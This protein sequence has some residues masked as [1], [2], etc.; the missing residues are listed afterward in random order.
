MKQQNAFWAFILA[1]GMLGAV[2]GG[3]VAQENGADQESTV[4]HLAG[5]GFF[6]G[7]LTAV[8]SVMP[9]DREAVQVLQQTGMTV[10]EP[11][12]NQGRPAADPV[13]AGLRPWDSTAA[14][15]ES[16]VAER[17][18][19]P[20]APSVRLQLGKYYAQTG[21]FDQALDQWRE[22][23]LLTRDRA[24]GQSVH[25]QALGRHALLLAELGQADEL[26]SLVAEHTDRRPEAGGAGY[27]WDRAQNILQ[28]SRG[29][30]ESRRRGLAILL[31]PFTPEDSPVTPQ[32]FDDTLI[33]E[34]D[35]GVSP[36][37]LIALADS[38][39]LDVRIAAP[40]GNWEP[41]VPSIV[42]LTVGTYVSVIRA[43]AGG[44]QIL[45]PAAG[46][47]QWVTPQELRE[48]ASGVV[49]VAAAVSE[50]DWPGLQA[51][52]SL[53]NVGGLPSDCPPFDDEDGPLCDEPC[54]PCPPGR[55]GNDA[56]LMP[57]A[58]PDCDSCGTAADSPGMVVWRVSEPF[59]NV[60]LEDVP[61][62]YEP[63]IGPS[64][65]LELGHRQRLGD[66]FG[67]YDGST[68]G[69]GFHASWR[70]SAGPFGGD[71]HYVYHPGGRIGHYHFPSSSSLMSERNYWDNS[72][73]EKL[74]DGAS[75][76]SRGY[77]LHRP[78]GSMLRYEHNFL[79][80]GDFYLT[81]QVDPQGNQLAFNYDAAGRLTTVVDADGRSTRLVYQGTS[82]LIREVV[83]PD[84]RRV[85]F[86]Y[87]WRY[88]SD[89]YLVSITDPVGI[90]SSFQYN[91]EWIRS[92]S[93]P[94]GTTSFTT[95]A[96]SGSLSRW[97]RVDKPEGRTHGYALVDTSAVGMPA[98]IPAAQRPN[99]SFPN[100]L[101]LN[102][103]HHRNTFYWNPQQWAA[104]GQT[105]I[106]GFGWTQYRRARIR[107]WLWE[108]QRHVDT[109]SYQQWPSPD[110]TEEG[111][112]VFLDYEGKPFPYY[113]GNQIYPSLVTWLTPEGETAY[114]RYDRNPLGKVTRERQT[115]QAADGTVQ[116]RTRNFTY[117]A[118]GI[119]LLTES[120]WSNRPLRRWVY[121]GSRL[122]TALHVYP[123]S[124]ETETTTVQYTNGPRVSKVITA[125]GLE[126]NHTYHGNGYLAQRI[127][128]TGGTEKFFWLNGNLTGYTDL[129][130]LRRT[131]TYDGLNRITRIGYGTD[132]SFYQLGQ[133]S[134]RY[135]MDGNAG[136]PQGLDL[137]YASDRM[138]NVHRYQYNGLRELMQY[139]DPMGRQ[140]NLEYCE[141]GALEAQVDALGQRTEWDRDFQ[142]R[143]TTI[144]F[145]GG[146][147]QL[148]VVYDALSRISSVADGK[149]TRTFAYNHQG[150]QTRLSSAGGEHWRR[151]FDQHG[152]VISETTA[153]N[154]TSTA[155]YDRL[156]RL[157]Q[158]TD[159]AGQTSE[160]TFGSRGLE[161]FKNALSQVT[162]L[163][164][165]ARGLLTSQRL[166]SG[167][168]RQFT[169]NWAGDLTALMDG[170]KRTSWY[171]DR[172]G[173]ALVKYE[174]N[175]SVD[176][177]RYDRLQRLTYW[178]AIS[179]TSFG[180][181][182]TYDAVG[183]LLSINYNG[184]TPDVSFT[185]DAL[186]RIT[187]MRDGIGL[188]KFEY[189]PDGRLKSED[190]PWA[191]DELE[192][193]YESGYRSRFSV[194]FGNGKWT[195]SY[196]Y[197]LVGRL[198]T[199]N[200][201]AGAYRYQYPTGK[202]TRNWN[203][204]DL[205][206]GG[207]VSR[208]FDS[209][210]RLTSTTLLDAGGQQ[211]NH[212]GYG[213]D[214]LHRRVR[215]TKNLGNYWAYTYDADGQL[216]TAKG[217]E[218]NGQPR[219][220]EDLTY[221][222]YSG[223]GHG[224]LKTRDRS[225][226]SLMR[227]YYNSGNNAMTQVSRNQPAE[228]LVSGLTS[229]PASSVSVNGVPA[230]V[231]PDGAYALGDVAQS[232]SDTEQTVVV[233]ATS[234]SGESVRVSEK[235]SLGFP[236]TGYSSSSLL[237]MTCTTDAAGNLSRA[238][239]RWFQY[240]GAKQLI[241]VWEAG[242]FKTE[243]QYDGLNRV[244]VRKRFSSIRNQWKL[245]EERRYLYDGMQ[246]V[247]ERD[248]AN[249]VVVSYTRGLDLSGSLAGAGG[250]GGLLAFSDHE[251]PGVRHAHYHSDGNGNITA[252]MNR[253][254]RLV[255]EYH[256]DPFGNLQGQAGPLAETNPYRFSSKQYQ[257]NTG[258]YSYGFR[259]Y[260]PS[261]QRWINQDPIAELGGINLYGF[262][263]SDP[264]NFV[265]S[266]GRAA[267]GWVAR[268]GW[269]IGVAIGSS[270]LFDRYVQP[271]IDQAYQRI[272][273]WDPL[274]GDIFRGAATG[275][276]VAMTVKNAPKIAMGICKHGGNLIR[277]G[278]GPE[279]LADLADQAKRA[280]DNGFP[281]GVSTRLKDRV[282]GSDRKHR[283]APKDEVEASFPVEQTGND[284]RHHTVILPKPV[285]SEVVDEFNRI[286]KPKST[287]DQ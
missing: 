261:L 208:Q 224:N 164:R 200:G 3:V 196:G 160:W 7:G 120:D 214:A 218:A 159:G 245:E 283:S 225:G 285:N 231:Y 156:G 72:R 61:L 117:S 128:S 97:V 175:Q 284:P 113:T 95:S 138:G 151:S 94:Y 92:F 220:H 70:S 170:S 56:S 100:Q 189:T 184:S 239:D 83:A 267:W 152:N 255:A 258:M 31:D 266:D 183:N 41:L 68:F 63:S 45:N 147:R 271:H 252:M 148:D 59:L 168:T 114:L 133:E 235:Y 16:F 157:I 102:F 15:A 230:T 47:P 213:F 188:T 210:G 11:D 192:W 53:A 197:D 79:N 169:Y 140:T 251:G 272:Y 154:G 40:S 98:T 84:G 216:S 115:Y 93:T 60:W 204:R 158:R 81:A 219:L 240:D 277:F 249:Q 262:V 62:E 254:G 194:G 8:G 25:D 182:P 279:S 2:P 64:V 129:R 28:R 55:G 286:F 198:K 253:H 71:T 80:S 275:V 48:G 104:L 13:G 136:G 74:V 190:G 119:D 58:E 155:V 141:C 69:H 78:D 127:Y 167:H 187:E 172:Y 121:N 257:P 57:G 112:I 75:G 134:Y 1:M 21:R 103:R 191:Q 137:T 221:Q 12:S 109:L 186:N 180:G 264:V 174:G 185:Y 50:R 49:L 77:A 90:R 66:D 106:P 10:T 161:E 165:D 54:G 181:R 135:T 260:E 280:E 244:R 9:A 171:L 88:G 241:A 131:M 139:T 65:R 46:R 132:F 234:P 35:Q 108:V 91:Q 76:Q 153:V 232:T 110:G 145:P 30:A 143:V 51:Q 246:I 73:L 256:Y 236:L 173:D 52:G 209:V 86:Q 42:H 163:T 273:A 32:A 238:G 179:N 222:Y 38:V 29:N 282:S 211:L 205:P 150:Q 36:S 276:E 243:Y 34:T 233:E 177:Y 44:Y 85:V 43:E 5:G 250:I 226:S 207:S 18:D 89:P 229:P 17:A 87:T 237:S 22:V 265:D 124:G 126:I 6:R 14:A 166:P 270:L 37:Q 149:T 26:E 24:E 248:G 178:S 33:Q 281:H 130:S 195:Q 20:F 144:R 101:D 105:S 193:G 278:K 215:Q 247:Q 122:P 27:L 123:K 118:D 203:T 269:T 274:A 67:Y 125:S 227:Y 176:W 23:E 268:G 116:E 217:F 39:G 4:E 202:A 82:R 146:T 259:F 111:L 201:P 206:G 242:R 223:I 19:S 107:H 96:N 199:V 142:G 263:G 287:I 99:L 212:H 228:V 162:V